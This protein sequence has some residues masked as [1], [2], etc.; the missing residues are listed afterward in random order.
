MP[1]LLDVAQG[2]RSDSFGGL[3]KSAENEQNRERAND[4][5]RRDA[6]SAHE[7]EH[8]SGAATGAA[9]GAQLTSVP[10]SWVGAIVGGVVGYLIP[11]LF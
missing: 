1:G 9:T 2:M 3:A 10:Y 7:N 11:D 8:M 4:K 6:K 5:I